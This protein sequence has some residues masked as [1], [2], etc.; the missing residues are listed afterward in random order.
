MERSAAERNLV[1]VRTE[2]SQSEEDLLEIKALVEAQAPDI[3]VFIV[4][5]RAI[6]SVTAR[7]AASRPALV[8]S[9]Y[10]LDQFR[11]RRGKVYAGRWIRKQEQQRLLEAHGIPIPKAVLLAPDTVLDPAEWGEMVVVKPTTERFTSYGKG[12][13]LRRTTA[14]RHVSPPSPAPGERPQASQHI[15][16]RFIDTGPCPVSYRVLTFLGEPIYSLR[17]RLVAPLGPLPAGDEA[18]AA[19]QI[20]ANSE[21][22]VAELSRDEEVLAMASRVHAVAPDVPLK[23]VDVVRDVRDGSLWVLEFNPGGNTWGFSSAVGRKVREMLGNGDEAHGR[24]ALKAHLDGFRTVARLLV[25]RTR[26]E[27]E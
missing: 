22:R 13:A 15:V 20:A 2:R 19:L 12:V 25:E 14:V 1:L 21:G 11:P 4:D 23:G 26:T 18:L 27:A 8:V 17:F 3:E 6:S 7:R 10:V 16:Q 5:N 24:E 9:N